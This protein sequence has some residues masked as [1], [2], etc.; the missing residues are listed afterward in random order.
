LALGL[1]SQWERHGDELRLRT[2]FLPPKL[3]RSEMTIKPDQRQLTP[4][5]RVE[6]RHLLRE[7]KTLRQVAAHFHVSRMAIWRLTEH[8]PRRDGGHEKGGVDT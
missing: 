4:E 7:G 5:E 1:S 3:E 2:E 6:A 8:H